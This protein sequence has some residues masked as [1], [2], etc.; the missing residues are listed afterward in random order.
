MKDLPYI[1]S[2]EYNGETFRDIPGYLG[3]YAVSSNGTV[4]KKERIVW[5]EKENTN[6]EVREKI[7]RQTLFKRRRGGKIDATVGLKKDGVKKRH[8]VSR[9]V[10][11]AWCDGYSP[12]LTVNHKYGNPSN[13]NADNLEW[14]TQKKNVQ[15]AFAN[16]LMNIEKPCALIDTKGRHRNFE[17][18]R[19][20]SKF[21][22][23]SE[24]YIHVCVFR[25]S[26][27]RDKR[28]RK[29]QVVNLE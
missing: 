3:Y 21:L 17:S 22:G 28:K 16:G 15:H 8:Y 29:Y 20:A 14:V 7:L 25:G 24:S 4:L 27:A 13:N 12:G 23:K 5:N 2:F 6:S 18:Y 9:L 1:Q 10:A 11:M 19:D 26:L